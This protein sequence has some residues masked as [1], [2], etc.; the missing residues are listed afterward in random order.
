M[1]NLGPLG[2]WG[3]GGD[4]LV[5]ILASLPCF[6]PVIPRPQL[7]LCMFFNVALSYWA[8]VTVIRISGKYNDCTCV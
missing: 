5:Q 7:K 1:C 2:V 8:P 3:G 4:S 6:F